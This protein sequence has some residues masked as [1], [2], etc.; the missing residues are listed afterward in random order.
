[1]KSDVAQFEAVSEDRYDNYGA[2]SRLFRIEID[3]DLLQSL[4]ESPKLPS[5]GN[6]NF[7]KGYSAIRKYLES[8]ND[9][10]KAVSDLAIDYA[11]IFIGYG[12]NP[13]SEESSDEQSLHA[14]YP[15]ESV[16]VTGS[17]TLSGK[18]NDEVTEEFSKSG[19]HPTKYRI[20]ANNHIACE[21]EFLQYLVGQ[22]IANVREGSAERVD[23]LRAVE[24]SF[25]EAHLL[26]WIDAFQA[27]IEKR[28]QL[29][30]YS[31]LTKMTKGW[32]EQDRR[33]L[34]ES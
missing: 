30:F 10:E 18:V 31:N 8:V 28:E 32:L 29:S 24:R 26:N 11:F 33:F 22:E 20:A 27:A 23:A 25:L 14:A 5:T 21:L 9:F 1:M 13:D 17:K 34:G 12:A 2:L 6:Q 19:F 4:C 7:D 3:D 15:Y 16:Y